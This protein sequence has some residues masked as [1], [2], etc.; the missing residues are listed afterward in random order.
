MPA[1]PTSVA[2]GSID[3]NRK[4]FDSPPAWLERAYEIVQRLCFVAVLTQRQLLVFMLKRRDEALLQKP[5]LIK[6]KKVH[7]E[8]ALAAVFKWYHRMY[9]RQ[10]KSLGHL[11]LVFY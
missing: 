5:C 1:T 10:H 6:R 3:F 11:H 4:R 8:N 7:L 9:G 2:A